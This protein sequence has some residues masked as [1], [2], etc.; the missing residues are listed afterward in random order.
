MKKIKLY[1]GEITMLF[2]NDSPNRYT[3]EQTGHVPVG[4]TSVIGKTIAKDGLLLW[5]MNMAL[6]HLRKYPDDFD[7]AASAHTKKSD[8]GKDV[9]TQV[10]QAIELMLSTGTIIGSSNKQADKALKAFVKWFNSTAMSAKGTERIIYSRKYD[11]AGTFDALME[12][13]G[14]LVL[15]DVKTTNASKTAPKGIYP[16][17]FI[18]LGAYSLAHHEEGGERVKDLMVINCN[19]QGVLSTCRAS[20]LGLS[21]LDC[22][23]AW[24]ACLKLYRFLA[25]LN[26]QLGEL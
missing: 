6:A 15:C 16:E 22:E 18:Q 7:G 8:K 11:Y 10:H 19:K 26:K 5:P 9:G 12:I 2:D 14:Q 21:V 24:K 23:R 3:I 20:E 17:Y 25:P 13:D 1:D 4:V